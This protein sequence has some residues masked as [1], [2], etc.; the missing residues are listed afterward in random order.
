M[1]VIA[2][3]ES[4]GELIMFMKGADSIMMPRMIIDTHPQKKLDTDLY[5]F[6]CKGL[7]TLVMGFKELDA[8]V[9]K[10]W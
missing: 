7:R 5:D 10:D 4:T 1:S 3:E 2:R 6:A 8:Q 9:W